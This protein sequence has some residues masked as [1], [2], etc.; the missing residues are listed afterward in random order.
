MRFSL[1]D[2][3]KSVQRHRGELSVSLHFLRPGEMHTEIEHLVAYYESLLGQPQRLFSLDDARACIGDY[4]LAHCLIATLSNWYRWRQREW[5]EAAQGL[6]SWPD[7]SSPTQLRLAL[8]QYVNVYYQGFLDTQTRA[9][10]LQA[11]AATYNISI[12]E[13]EYLLVVDS[14][15]EAILVRDAPQVPRVQEIATCYNQWA[16][17]SALFN[18]SSVYFVIDCNTFAKSQALALTVGTG[19]GA[20]IKRLCYLAKLFGVYY[21]FT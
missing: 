1:Q 5:T 16:F 14:E 21:D 10:A 11:F 2:V 18:A 8:Y 7:L 3:K 9:Q 15:D 13:L 4:R 17:E 12:S 20:A 19:V 6:A